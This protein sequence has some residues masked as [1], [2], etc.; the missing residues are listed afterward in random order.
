MTNAICWTSGGTVGNIA[1]SSLIL[2]G[3]FSAQSGEDALLTCDLVP[4]GKFRHGAERWWCR[5]HQTYWGTKTDYAAYH[6]SGIRRCK[7]YAQPVHYVVAP[8]EIDLSDYAEVRI[9]CS[10][11]AAISTQPITERAARIYVYL[12]SEAQGGETIDQE[13]ETIAVLCPRDAGLFGSDQITRITITPPVALAFVFALA[14]EREIGCVH[15]SRCGYPHLDLGEF[16]RKPHRKHLCGNCGWDS[17]WSVGAIVST[18]LKRLQDRL[19]KNT[20]W[21]IPDTTLDLD[22]YSGCD[23][24][25]PASTPAIL[26]KCDRPQEQGIHVQVYASSK[27]IVDG[28]FGTV[29]L[30]GK[31]LERQ[32]LL[33]IMQDRTGS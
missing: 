32:Q 29:R 33:Q 25:L 3:R 21:Y 8:V 20:E 11:P 19:A 12:R 15:C 31:T 22:G 9:G 14:Q 5:S 24:T 27:A 4:A 26:W 2:S 7:H 1:V 10:L 17:T 13:F 30:K 28:I 18:P 16:A 6:H 23:Y